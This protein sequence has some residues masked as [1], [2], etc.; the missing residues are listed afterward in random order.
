MKKRMVA[1]VMAVMM[2]ATMTGCGKSDDKL[3]VS[4]LSL[5]HI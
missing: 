1:M 3:T 2:V 4:E 5:I